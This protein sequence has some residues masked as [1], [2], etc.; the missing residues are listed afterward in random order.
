VPQYTLFKLFRLA[1]DGL[2]SFSYVPLQLASIAGFVISGLA[3]LGVLTV[4]AWKLMGLL[5]S[6]A[7]TATI[8]LS[9]LLLGGFQLLT[10]G[11]LGEYVGRIFDEVKRR[12]VAMVAEL[13]KHENTVT[14]VHVLE[15]HTANYNPAVDTAISASTHPT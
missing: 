10:I 5:P 7:A 15:R 13:L 3:F 2:V 4:L 9:V 1:A 11:I 12:P 6:G 14:D 8:A